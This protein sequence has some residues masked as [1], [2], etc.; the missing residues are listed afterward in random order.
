VT[1]SGIPAA[2]VSIETRIAPPALVATIVGLPP[3][4]VVTSV[5]GLGVAPDIIPDSPVLHD[6]APMT[7][8]E[9]ARKEWIEELD[10]RIVKT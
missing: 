8:S 10:F 7:N 5:V 4:P 3:V 1:V 6:E 2:A 9:L